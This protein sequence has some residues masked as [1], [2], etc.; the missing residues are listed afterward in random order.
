MANIAETVEVYAA[1]LTSNVASIVSNTTNLHNNENFDFECQSISKLE[2]N[3]LKNTSFII[4]GKSY[5]VMC[6]KYA[7]GHIFSLKFIC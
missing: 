6:L 2:A 7:S 5:K 3:A 4:E 1:N